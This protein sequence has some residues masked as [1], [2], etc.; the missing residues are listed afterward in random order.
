MT[1]VK[2]G[3]AKQIQDVE[4]Q[5]IFIHCYGHTLNL[6]CGDAMKGCKVLKSALKT[7][8]EISKHIKFSPKREV[9]FKEK[10]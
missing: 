6:A 2:K 4:K 1:G 3:A 8:Q 7:T 9:L 10:K 5:A